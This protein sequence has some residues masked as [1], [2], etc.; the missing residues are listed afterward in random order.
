[1]EQLNM[2][3]DLFTMVYPAKCLFDNVPSLPH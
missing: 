1:M 2:L 3:T